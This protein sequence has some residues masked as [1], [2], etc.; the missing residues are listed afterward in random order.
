LICIEREDG[1]RDLGVYV[2]L[3]V[4]GENGD[5]VSRFERERANA[6]AF[7]T[8]E[9]HYQNDEKLGDASFSFAVYKDKEIA[10]ALSKSFRRKCAYCES[11]FAAVTPADIEHY[12]PK[13][14]I[15][16]GQREL[17][18]G[19]YWLAGDW[20]NLLLSCPH[21]NRSYQHEVPGQTKNVTLG[22]GSQFPLSDE[23]KRVRS[24]GGDIATE[25]DYRLLLHPCIDRPEDHLSFGTD[26]LVRA[27]RKGAEG[28]AAK[29]S[30]DVYALQRKDLVEARRDSLNELRSRVE[31]LVFHVLQH[32]RFD[33]FGDQAAKVR[34]ENLTQLRKVLAGVIAAMEPTE[35]YLAAK[36]QWIK[37]A[38][39]RGEFGL[40][41]QFGIDLRSLAA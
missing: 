30:I 31:D 28:E 5:K 9:S 25:A 13:G 35:Q 20:D 19:Y 22:K 4:R 40:L 38:E 24:H 16:T 23:T 36:R 10:K 29:A 3:T 1:T 11:K 26:G 17:K 21:C 37:S 18:P 32:G 8:D 14:S 33:A 27:S 12:R 6:I 2:K 39:A 15:A 34:A 41:S 7:F